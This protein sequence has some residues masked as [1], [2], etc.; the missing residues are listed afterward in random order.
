MLGIYACRKS[1]LF[2]QIKIFFVLMHVAGTFLGVV[3]F[4]V[5]FQE[6]VVES[7]QIKINRLISGDVF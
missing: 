7:Q 1:Q 6:I 5:S 3:D 4:S 2:Y